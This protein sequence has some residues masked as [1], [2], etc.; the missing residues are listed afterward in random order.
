[1]PRG[2]PCLPG[3]IAKCP[4]CGG[5]FDRSWNKY[6]GQKNRDGRHYGGVYC[7]PCQYRRAVAS[8]SKRD[9]GECKCDGCGKMFAPNRRKVWDVGRGLRTSG[10]YCSAECCAEARRVYVD[11]RHRAREHKRRERARKH[12]AGLRSDGKPYACPENAADAARR[13]VAPTVEV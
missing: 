13:Y 1:M 12:A 2:L 6:S 9:R 4:D 5:T 3:A 8:A 10:W 11:E 7:R